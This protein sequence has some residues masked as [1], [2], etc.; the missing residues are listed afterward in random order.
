MLLLFSLF[1]LIL[2]HYI[3]YHFTLFILLLLVMMVL[4]VPLVNVSCLCICYRNVYP[5]ILF[6]LKFW[7][8]VWFYFGNPAAELRSIYY[9]LVF[10]VDLSF[11]LFADLYLVLVDWWYVFQRCWFVV[12]TQHV[13]LWKFTII[14]IYFIF[15]IYLFIYLFLI[16]FHYIYYLFFILLLLVMIVL[17]VFLVNVSC[18]CIW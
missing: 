18:L 6:P 14:S 9:L 4:L 12:G 1:F 10:H 15:I 3:Y 7:L 16:L 17:L 13:L 11:R 2:F 8:F 5:M